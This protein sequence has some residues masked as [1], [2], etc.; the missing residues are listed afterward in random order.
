[1]NSFVLL[2]LS[3]FATAE[4]AE[5]FGVPTPTRVVADQ[6]AQ[7][8]AQAAANQ[9]IQNPGHGAND[10]LAVNANHVASD[11][12]ASNPNPT[13]SL[14]QAS[15]PADAVLE[16]QRRK[17]ADCHGPDSDKRKAKRKYP[18][19]LDLVA[20][21]EEWIVPGKPMESDLY[22]MLADGEMP[23]ED[24]DVKPVT[25]S[26]LATYRTWI[27]AGAPTAVTSAAP[28][29]K[30]NEAAPDQEVG[31]EQEAAPDQEGD[32]QQ[33]KIFDPF[34]DD[35]PEVQAAEVV[36]YE[37][38]RRFAARQH[39]AVVHFPIGLILSAAMLE[40]L[41]L[42]RRR[43]SWLYAQRFCLRFGALTAVVA[44]G[45]GL[46]LTEFTLVND[47]LWLHGGLAAAA[48]LCTLTAAR[49]VPKAVESRRNRFRL[50]LGAAALL[51]CA[52]GFM[53]G[54][55]VFGWDYLKY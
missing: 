47:E 29:S 28:V 7:T 32:P 31:A 43:E 33:S 20:T 30:I 41:I 10:L 26:E 53:G 55:M 23:P 11:I 24:S 38:M 40:F 52:T 51:I 16:I 22:L 25:A 36:G 49:G 2:V 27:E 3:F 54:Y 42:L 35:E 15:N 48:L 21:V 50:W 8:P 34:E 6:K 45:L 17:C 18:D 46:M 5:R 14:N 37:R 12:L 19:A 4:Q 9:Q 44:A 1:M 13:A 39:P